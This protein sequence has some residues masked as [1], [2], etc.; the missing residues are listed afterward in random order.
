MQ[1]LAD[2]QTTAVTT[3]AGGALSQVAR[4]RFT[5][6]PVAVKFQEG[7]VFRQ[8]GDGSTMSLWLKPKG[9]FGVGDTAASAGEWVRSG[10]GK[11]A[12]YLFLLNLN[13]PQIN[14]LWTAD[15]ADA[16]AESHEFA[17]ELRWKDP[18]VGSDERSAT[19]KFVVQNAVQ[20]G[21]E[22]AAEALNVLGAEELL[23][24]A[25]LL[26][27]ISNAGAAAQAAARAN[28]GVAASRRVPIPSNPFAGTISPGI[29]GD[30]AIDTANERR[31]D[32]LGDG[33]THAWGYSV[34]ITA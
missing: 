25:N 11:S 18:V 9:K 14:A 22:E 34:L 10:S 13:T 28:L 19:I 17:L 7:G 12:V 8:L 15:G 23:Q 26:S 33:T 21:V 5:T 24:V 20:Q 3:W 2:I 4:K 6:F 1:L 29:P 32:Y 16:N 27:E 31:W 30:Y